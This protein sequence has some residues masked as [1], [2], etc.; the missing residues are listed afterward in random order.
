MWA[1]H[2]SLQPCPQDFECSPCPPND[3]DWGWEFYDD[4]QPHMWDYQHRRH[5]DEWHLVNG[6]CAG[7]WYL[8]EGHAY[9]QSG[10]WV[11]RQDWGGSRAEVK[12][13]AV[14]TG[15]FPMGELKQ[16]GPGPNRANPC[17]VRGKLLVL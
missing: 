13:S 2:L 1:C 5:E 3:E 15:L 11:S 4:W 14:F 10:W 17:K 16:M 7:P 9:E 6:V 8:G 12:T